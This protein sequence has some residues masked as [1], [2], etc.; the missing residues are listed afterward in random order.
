MKM[1][2]APLTDTFVKYGKSREMLKDVDLRE[3]VGLITNE[4]INIRKV[5]DAIKQSPV[6]PQE[7]PVYGLMINTQ[8]GELKE[9]YR[10]QEPTIKSVTQTTPNPVIPPIQ[11]VKPVEKPSTAQPEKSSDK[12]VTTESKFRTKDIGQNIAK[13]LGVFFKNQEEWKNKKNNL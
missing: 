4:E 5:V 10:Y 11:E 2:V 12:K 7:I 9:V 6:I 13:K 8:T 1:D 3:W